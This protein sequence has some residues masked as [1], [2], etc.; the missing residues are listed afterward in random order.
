MVGSALLR[1]IA[2]ERCEILT[3]DRAALDLRRQDATEAWFDAID[4]TLFS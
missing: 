2:Q 3:A 4:P 1:R